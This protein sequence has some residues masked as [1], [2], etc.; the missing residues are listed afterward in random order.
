MNF[1]KRLRQLRLE[2]KMTQK[3]L[4]EALFISERVISY[5]ESGQRFPNDEIILIQ[6]AQY[7]HVSLDY[8]LGVSESRKAPAAVSSIGDEEAM[9]FI[10]RVYRS[11]DSLIKGRILQFALDMEKQQ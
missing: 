5:Y 3:E 1:S 7:F 9:K 10:E 2:W 6:I 11:S 4:G 8:L